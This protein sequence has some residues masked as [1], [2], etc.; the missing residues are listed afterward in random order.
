MGKTE[1]KPFW[2]DTTH[3]RLQVNTAL[4]KETPEA[5]TWRLI[6]QMQKRGSQLDIQRFLDGSSRHAIDAYKQTA[7]AGVGP[8]PGAQKPDSPCGPQ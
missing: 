1:R 7:G 6:D 5:R 2:V 3:R 8:A 4:R